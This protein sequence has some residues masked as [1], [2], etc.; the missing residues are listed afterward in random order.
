MKLFLDVIQLLQNL[1]ERLLRIEKIFTIFIFW[2]YCCFFLFYWAWR[3]N[4]WTT[5]LKFN[6]WTEWKIKSL[7]FNGLSNFSWYSEQSDLEK[8]LTSLFTSLEDVKFILSLFKC[9]TCSYSLS[10]EGIKFIAIVDWIFQVSDFIKG[11][12][13]LVKVDEKYNILKS[14]SHYLLIERCR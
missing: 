2:I 8:S 14:A 3:I 7:P 13:I 12:V 10:F 5:A 11:I 1:M 9:I 6:S 4:I